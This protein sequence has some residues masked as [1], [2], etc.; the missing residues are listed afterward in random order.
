MKFGY[1]AVFPR[2]FYEGIDD[3][4][5]NGFDFVQFDL[6]VPRFFLDPLSKAELRRIADYADGKGVALTFHAP[7]DNVS[8][9][10]D[11]PLIRQGIQ[12]Q[13]K[14]ILD[15]ANT[16][17]ARHI[18]FHTGTYPQFKK[19]GCKTDDSGSSYYAEV[20]YENLKCL[21]EH[22]GD[23]LC[24]VENLG[25]NDAIRRAIRRFFDAQLPLYLTLDTAKMDAKG[26]AIHEADFDFFSQHKDRIRE[27]HVHDW[28]EEY[29][30]HQTVG[31]GRIDFHRFQPFLSDAVYLNYEV[32]PV[33]AA[34]RSMD[35]CR[36]IWGI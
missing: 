12:D 18:T 15:K 34:K 26:A 21:T 29:G 5:H 28:N 23:V 32:R 1:H 3:A 24:C 14:L 4:S 35:T 27:M 20:L 9:M 22:C 33:E 8:L 31:T 11:Y 7:G 6:G 10:C 30:G 16:L 13:C 36:A 17:C 25:W 2:D 19:S